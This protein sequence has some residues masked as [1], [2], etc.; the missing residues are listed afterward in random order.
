MLRI[1]RKFPI[2]AE[3]FSSLRS[4]WMIE[5][6]KSFKDF[7]MWYNNKDVL[8]T[9]EAMQKVKTFFRQKEIDMLM[10]GCTL[11]ISANNRLHKSLESKFYPFT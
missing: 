2:G 8:P 1:D 7:L 4:V 5:R 10:L 3:N 6:M 9:L 11:P